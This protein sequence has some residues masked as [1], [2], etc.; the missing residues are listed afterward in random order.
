MKARRCYYTIYSVLDNYGKTLEFDSK[1]AAQDCEDYINKE[2][3]V[4]DNIRKTGVTLVVSKDHDVFYKCIPAFIG[5]HGVPFCEARKD[6][7]RDFYMASCGHIDSI[8]VKG[9]NLIRVLLD[10]YNIMCTRCN[11]SFDYHDGSYHFRWDNT[12]G[13]KCSFMCHPDHWMKGAYWYNWD[14]ENFTTNDP[15][16]KLS[17]KDFLTL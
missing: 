2:K 12:Y 10:F 1:E 6:K 14:G 15:S 7:D 9:G 3:V 16:C 11:T 4:L 17:A 5:F 8:G 13:H